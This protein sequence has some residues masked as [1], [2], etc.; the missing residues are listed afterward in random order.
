MIGQYD[1]LSHPY[2]LYYSESEY[3]SIQVITQNIWFAYD[4]FWFGFQVISLLCFQQHHYK[5]QS[6]HVNKVRNQEMKQLKCMILLG[7]AL[8]FLIFRVML[9]FTYCT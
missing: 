7:I 3:E 6:L 2:F 9:G 1:H 4:G 5:Q 8:V